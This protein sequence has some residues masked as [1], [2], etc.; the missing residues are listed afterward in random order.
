MF[1][2]F[3]FFLEKFR[4]FPKLEATLSFSL[5]EAAAQNEIFNRSTPEGQKETLQ[6][7]SHCRELR[8]ISKAFMV[9]KLPMVILM[10]IFSK[11]FTS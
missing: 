5:S 9:G 6:K 11:N 2:S 8:R 4:S 3:E 1:V 10:G 7:K